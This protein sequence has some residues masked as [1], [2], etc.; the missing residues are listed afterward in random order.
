[1]PTRRTVAKM[2]VA[3]AL[4][5]IGQGPSGFITGAFA[6]NAPALVPRGSYLI[7]GGAVITVDS[8]PPSVTIDTPA[9]GTVFGA[10]PITVSGTVRS[11]RLRD[12]RV[13]GTVAEINGDRFTARNIP[14]PPGPYTKQTRGPCSERTRRRTDSSC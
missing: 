2:L 14:I 13:N 10:S 3:T 11:L 1:M 5:S 9:S 12:V 4:G 8:Q 7:K 6:Q